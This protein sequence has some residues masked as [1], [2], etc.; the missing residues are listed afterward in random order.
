MDWQQ[1]A[2]LLIV[3]VTAGLFIWSRRRQRKFDFQR[4]THCGCDSPAEHNPKS[5]IIFRARRG[6]RPE[7]EIKTR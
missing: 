7:I 3:G 1:I 2:S 6:Q 4:D 5:S